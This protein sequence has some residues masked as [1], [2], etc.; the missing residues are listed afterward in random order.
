MEH[1]RSKCSYQIKRNEMINLI[2]KIELMTTGVYQAKF[3]V[4]VL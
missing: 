4:P 1:K 3:F 2:Y